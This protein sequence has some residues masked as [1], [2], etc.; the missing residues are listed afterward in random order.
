M[1][2]PSTSG[3]ARAS[4][5]TEIALRAIAP[6]QRTAALVNVGERRFPETFV[7]GVATAAPQVEGAAWTDDKG[8]SIWDRFCRVPGKIHNGDT[9]DIACDHYHRYEEDFALMARLGVRNYRMSIAW[10]RIFPSG[11]GPHSQK[12]LDFYHRLIDA[13]LAKG[14]TPWV[15]MFHWDLPQA[16][17]DA[18]GWRVPGVVQA[19]AA[20]ADTIVRAYGDRVKNWITLNEIYCFTELAYGGGDKA[21]GASEGRAVVNQTYHHA[22]LCHGHG[23]R[24]VR[25]H[26]GP[27]ARVGLA[28]NA[29]VSIPVSETAADIAAARASFVADNGRVLDAIYRGRY[30]PEYLAAAGAA[31]P[32]H[33]AKDFELISLPTDFLGLNIYTGR[34]VRSNAAGQPETIPFAGNYPRADSPWLWLAPRA[35]YWGTRHVHEIY[36]EKS[37]LITENGSGYNE[38][39]TSD[40]EILDINRVEY[41]RSCLQELARAID[42]GVPVAGYFLWSF[43][44]NFEWQDGYNRRFGIVHVDFI[45]QKRT[46]KLSA[47]WF[48][49]VITKNCLV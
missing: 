26:G 13:A 3:A 8:S 16:L 2:L 32:V 49:Q 23:V 35:L 24:A 6:G 27:G 11:H 37:I 36:G 20:Y 17:E 29:S 12:G 45:S 41:A 15:T 5:A 25:E 1:V 43:M 42:D 40:G 38:P 22:L 18:G 30:A 9:L 4:T 34:F 10:P 21:P 31:A 48:S 47:R 28:D 44:D 39:A 19:F 14:V 7:W 46:P 33:T